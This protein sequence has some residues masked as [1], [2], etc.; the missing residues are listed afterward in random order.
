[1]D[2]SFWNI[3]VPYQA[4]KPLEPAREKWAPK[5]LALKTNEEYLQENRT[6]ELQGTEK[7]LLKGLCA[8]LF[9]RKMCRNT[10][11]RSTKTRGEGAYLLILKHLPA[12]TER[13]GMC[14]KD[15]DTGSH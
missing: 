13:G 12:R 6:I 15:W 10:W 2:F 9:D 1:M 5:H 14:P 3:R 8:Y 11:L 4:P 7:L